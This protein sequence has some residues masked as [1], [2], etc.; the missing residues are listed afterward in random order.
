MSDLVKEVA[1]GAKPFKK[2][3]VAIMLWFMGRAVQAAAKADAEVKKEFE[4]LPDDFTFALGVLPNGPWMVVGKEKGKVKYF[5]WNPDAKKLDLR[6]GVKGVEAAILMFTFQ[7]STALATS[8][9]RLIISGELHYALAFMRIMGIVETYL[10]PKIIVQLA[11]KRY[12]TQW[13]FGRK[14]GGRLRVY[15]R[16]LLGF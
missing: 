6:L 12:P 1:A 15:T 13:S 2:A 4:A 10:L 3:Y 5:G 14:Y 9:N 11:V 16:A 7:E 8:R